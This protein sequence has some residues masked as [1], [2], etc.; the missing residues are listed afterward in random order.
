MAGGFTNVNPL[1]ALQ[2]L[3]NVD[4]SRY[5]RQ[6]DLGTRR[7]AWLDEQA[8]IAQNS[9]YQLKA[10][11]DSYAAQAAERD[12]ALPALDTT[13]PPEEQAAQQAARRAQ[14]EK[15]AT[16]NADK[17][18]EEFM[19]KNKDFI[20]KTA[21]DLLRSNPHVQAKWA[22]LLGG[23]REFKGIRYAKT[24]SA[25][26]AIGADGKPVMGADGKPM[27][28]YEDGPERFA[29]EV[30]NRKTGTTG[31][32][33]STPEGEAGS[34]KTVAMTG[35][36]LLGNLISLGEGAA[37][38]RGGL[39]QRTVEAGM[40]A[41]GEVTNQG[42]EQQRAAG[43]RGSAESARPMANIAR[44]AT[45]M[46][47]MT[48]MAGPGGGSTPTGSAA[49]GFGAAYP[50]YEPPV[51]PAAVPPV[52]A[53]P[54]ASAT[55]PADDK[56]LV[57]TTSLGDVVTAPVRALNAAGRF[58]GRE[59]A[60]LDQ[61]RSEAWAK[62]K[63][64]SLVADV[65]E[66]FKKEGSLGPLTT[67]KFNALEHSARRAM[68][69]DDPG[70]TTVSRME[71]EAN[72]DPTLAAELRRRLGVKAPS[73]SQPATPYA[74]PPALQ[75]R[76]VRD[77]DDF[78]AAASAAGMT[79]PQYLATPEGSNKWAEITRKFK[80]ADVQAMQDAVINAGV[81]ARKLTALNPRQRTVLALMQRMGVPGYSPQE[82][83][84]RR[85]GRVSEK[86]PFV[87]DLQAEAMARVLSQSLTSPAQVDTSIA[88]ARMNE[89]GEM[90]RAAMTIASKRGEAADDVYKNLTIQ[91][92]RIAA[93]QFPEDKEAAAAFRAM[94]V[95]TIPYL[96]NRGV[97][98]SSPLEQELAMQNVADFFKKYSRGG[99]GGVLGFFKTPNSLD[100][101]N[102][103]MI[104]EA[105]NPSSLYP[106]TGQ[107]AAGVAEFG[108]AAKS[109]KLPPNE[110]ALVQAGAYNDA[111]RAYA[112]RRADENF[113]AK[114]EAAGIPLN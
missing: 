44:D 41:S 52:Q 110:A 16:D 25:R 23:H 54:A 94:T 20:E 88:R 39:G 98:F 10:A 73:A 21:G 62:E 4:Q 97:Q 72:L 11:R 65:N 71:R 29:I 96:M 109:G 28:I 105:A 56:P 19:V 101:A 74:P 86:D 51:P 61:R 68:D 7:K 35:P 107:Y 84:L 30:S 22:E 113:R 57:E 36:E 108:A 18:S 5:E 100:G 49:V 59:V 85:Q 99:T 15:I 70:G 76:V 8:Q 93:A 87:T 42:L 24:R 45:S 26:Q 46:Q 40:D 83:D 53:A 104:F 6:V 14:I 90:Q 103:E 3:E 69:V 37:I 1:Q 9:A 64:P 111:Y 58:V 81:D 75:E 17:Y 114:A 63:M 78:N 27:M 33:D 50:G 55:P 102:A 2:T 34:T 32:L 91:M 89:R 106:G 13:L 60:G 82:I 38:A 112:L 66:A 48:D 80:P 77:S 79:V 67:A 92:D 47:L 43:L 31:L 95:R 12:L